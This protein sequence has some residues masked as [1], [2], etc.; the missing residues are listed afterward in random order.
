MSEKAA[1]SRRQFLWGAGAG[2]SLVGLAGCAS[3]TA[4]APQIP[5]LTPELVRG[6]DWPRVRSG[7][8][9]P[10]DLVYLNCGSL[11]P[12]PGH[13][14]SEALS[15][16]LNLEQNPANEGYGPCIQRMEEVRGKAAEFL[17]CSKD[18]V[19]ITRNTTDGMNTVAQGLDLQK[20]QRVLTTDHEH[21]GGEVCWQYYAKRRG[22][23]V[24]TVELPVPAQSE[25][26]I[27][28]RFE[29]KLTRD[30]RV[31]SVSHVTFTTGLRMPVRRIAQMARANGSIVV[32][33]GA[34]APGMMEVNVEDLLCHAYATS[35]HKWMLGPKGVGILYVSKDAEGAIDP[36]VLQHGRGAYTASTGTR[37]I[38]TIIGLGA[39]IDFLSAV[40]KA[41]IERRVLELRKMLVEGLQGCAG[42][43][44][45]SPP[46]G[47][48]ASGMV[49][50]GLPAGVESSA[51]AS[52][53]M[54]RHRVVVKV[55]PARPVSGI[56]ISL[57]LYNSP[58]DVESLL[59]ALR[60]EVRG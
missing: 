21:P 16:W 28:K 36:L 48:M 50:V 10:D 9:L 33:D 15:A 23:V 34:Q 7:F 58:A 22:V 56:R 55:L 59:A 57:H 60:A 30:I 44:M 20:G 52:R 41:R 12:C 54:E 4:R 14:V 40:G 11:G 45:V 2:C 19:A 43:K 27:L 53:L 8:M 47:P 3:L 38:P 5:D 42:V 32:V 24:D 37:D 6:A 25:E 29:A 39:A 49:S 51:L 18:Q 1:V 35:G 13:V 26:E 46:E 31:V 17:G